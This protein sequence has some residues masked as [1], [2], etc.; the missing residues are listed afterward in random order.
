MACSKIIEIALEIRSNRR[1]ALF[2]ASGYLA[3]PNGRFILANW[4]VGDF[5]GLARG[6]WKPTLLTDLTCEGGR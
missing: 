1:P 3:R 5:S 6:R 2:E 4:R